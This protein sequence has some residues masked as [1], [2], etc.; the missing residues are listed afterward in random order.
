MNTQPVILTRKRSKGKGGLS[1]SS[2][3]KSFKWTAARKMD[4]AHYVV[5]NYENYKVSK[6]MDFLR[7]MREKL[8]FNQCDDT[9]LKNGFDRFMKA[10]TDVKDKLQQSGFGV[11]P[12][13]DETLNDG[14]ILKKCPYFHI[15]DEIMGS[16]PNIQP[17]HIEQSSAFGEIGGSE[18]VDEDLFDPMSL[19]M[20][21][22]VD[23]V[24]DMESGEDNPS[25]INV[26][27]T[28]TEGENSIEPGEPADGDS[29]V[30]RLVKSTLSGLGVKKAQKPKT[31]VGVFSSIMEL[32]L[33][34]QKE[35]EVKHIK[36]E[37]EKF[38]YTRLLDDKK[39]DLDRERAERELT[40]QEKRHELDR[41]MKLKELQ[42]VEDQ[43]KHELLK[44]EKQGEIDIRKL[45][46]QIELQKLKNQSQ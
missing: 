7:R 31:A 41:E 4:V 36:L 44:I 1:S 45:E 25:D 9:Q 23:F 3:E 22:P 6:K 39:L 37:E 32:R 11:D 26:D 17:P 40:L 14:W 10:Y 12:E 21:R 24:I 43:H 16:R 29:E 30:K 28:A 18:I 46:M 2:N 34:D 5:E 35:V 33:Q 15:L 19:P 20:S 8:R 13:K 42:L 27:L 38:N